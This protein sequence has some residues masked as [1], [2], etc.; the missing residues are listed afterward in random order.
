MRSQ[1]HQNGIVEA[2][3]LDTNGARRIVLDSARKI[4]H[5]GH[6]LPMS[7]SQTAQQLVHV[8]NQAEERSHGCEEG[9]DR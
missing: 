1:R 5:Y 7:K 2:T 9:E 8:W 4:A 6:R 3:S